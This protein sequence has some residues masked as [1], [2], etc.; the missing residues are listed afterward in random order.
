MIF[1]LCAV[2]GNSG[3]IAIHAVFVTKSSGEVLL[4]YAGDSSVNCYITPAFENTAWSVMAVSF[5]S[6]LAVSAVLATFFFVRRH[7]LRHHGWRNFGASMARDSSGMSSKEVKALPWLIFRRT[8]NDDSGSVTCPICLEDYEAG[9]KL[10]V[11]PCQ[12]GRVSLL[13]TVGYLCCD[14]QFCR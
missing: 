11:L 7:R 10:R 6:L 1:L 12:H 8:I 13:V 2:S 9:E 14:K 5:I 3:G 4:S